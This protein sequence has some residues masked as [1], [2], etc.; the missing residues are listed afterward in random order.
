[1]SARIRFYTIAGLVALAALA[2]I[3]GAVFWASQ[4]RP[5]FYR[6]A[7]AQDATSA[8]QGSDALLHEAAAL[9]SDLRRPGQWHALFTTEQINGW[10]ACD[11]LQNHPQL[12]P[13]CITDP[14]IAIQNNQAE[15]AFSWHKAGWSAVVS[16]EA[17]IYLRDTNVVAIRICRARAGLLPLPLAGLL[18]DLADTGRNAG[19]QIDEEQIEGDPLI[20]ITLPWADE[21]ANTRQASKQLCLDSLE[22]NDGEIYVAGHT[23]RGQQTVSAPE[24]ASQ[25][26]PA[27]EAHLLKSN[28]QR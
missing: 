11:V 22:V 25:P 8:K 20:L 13:T 9:A 18:K 15:I 10:L 16:L 27:A 28:I 4:H 2:L 7:L 1:V 17:E 6:Q 3:V 26:K 14:R 19:L 5:E 24:S 12:F 23:Q 21:P